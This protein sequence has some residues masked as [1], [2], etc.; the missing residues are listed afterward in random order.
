MTNAGYD[1]V[2]ASSGKEAL[3]KLASEMPDIITVDAFMS[4]MNGYELTRNIRAKE[5][6]KDIP[7]I[8]VTGMRATADA[9]D[10]KL[11]GA[12]DFFS[13]PVD[14]DKLLKTVKALLDKAKEKGQE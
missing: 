14:P 10:A 13:K 3:E 2:T 8:M 6:S 9:I 4:E 12:N 1:V 5:S 11:S 7:I